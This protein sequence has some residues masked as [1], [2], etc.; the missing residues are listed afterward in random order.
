MHG[1]DIIHGTN[2][3]TEVLMNHQVAIKLAQN[4]FTS[5]RTKH[6]EAH[7]RCLGQALKEAVIELKYCPL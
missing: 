4:E 2:H 7:Y 3:A 5:R 6:I 1:L